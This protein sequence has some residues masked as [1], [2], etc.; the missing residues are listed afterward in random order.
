MKNILGFL[1]IAVLGLTFAA[2]CGKTHTPTDA[3]KAICVD[4][5]AALADDK[6]DAD[7]CK[8][9]VTDAD[10]KYECKF[11]AEKGTQ[12]EDGYEAAKCI[13]EGK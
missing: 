7:N 1:A 9:L 12:G 5:F 8:A 4:G 3:E 6:K 13:A 10:A 2:G 11:H